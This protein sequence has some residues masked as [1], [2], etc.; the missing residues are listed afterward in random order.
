MLGTM[1][2]SHSLSSKF[3]PGPA[4][5]KVHKKQQREKKGKEKNEPH[6]HKHSNS[7]SNPVSH[8]H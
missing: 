6:R 3:V 4:I 2:Y 5:L 8:H 7:S 1:S